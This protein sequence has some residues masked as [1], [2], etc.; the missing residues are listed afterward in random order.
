MSRAVTRPIS[1]TRSGLN[2]AAPLICCGK[3]TASWMNPAPWTESNPYR[4]GWPPFEL[5]AISCSLAT[6]SRYSEAFHK[7]LAVPLLSEVAP[8]RMG[9]PKYPPDLMSAY[10]FTASSD[11]LPDVSVSR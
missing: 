4:I 5:M 3:N 10:G 2:E 8:V 1:L 6:A 11:I 7:Y 9:E